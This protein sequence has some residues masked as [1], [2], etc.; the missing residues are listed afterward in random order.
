MNEQTSIKIIK[1]FSENLNHI[2]G[3]TC[4]ISSG[5]LRKIY[6]N[7]YDN[8]RSEYCS[9]ERLN[10]SRRELSRVLEFNLSS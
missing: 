10:L 1:F 5:Q 7:F 9:R 4:P 8:Y 3:E 2:R 6:C